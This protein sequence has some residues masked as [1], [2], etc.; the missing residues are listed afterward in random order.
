MLANCKGLQLLHQW[1]ECGW[2]TVRSIVN[3]VMYHENKIRPLV[4]SANLAVLN[5][6]DDDYTL[7]AQN[8]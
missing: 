2:A 8:A 1:K 3:V 5:V 4:T 7:H 6:D